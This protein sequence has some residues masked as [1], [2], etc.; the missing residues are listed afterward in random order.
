MKLYNSKFYHRD[1]SWLRF[2]HRV[3][4]EA[5]DKLNPLYERIKFLAIFS[6]NLDE[7]FRVRVSDIRQIR[8]VEK[9]LRK[10]L[11]TKPNKVL[12]EIKKQVDIQQTAFGKV[13]KEEIIPDL[14]KENIFLI[15]YHEFSDSQKAIANDYFEKTLKDLLA[16]ETTYHKNPDTIF[17]ENEASYLCTMSGETL[18]LV[19]IP[20]S[21]PRF[22]SFPSEGGKHYISFID[23][24]LKYNLAKIHPDDA[25][26]Y[27]ALKIS[28]DAELYIEDE[29]SGD[30]MKKIKASLPKRDK[31]QPTR[32]L[33][34]ERMPKSFQ[35]ILMKAL[36]VYNADLILGGRHHN[37]K[38]FFSFPNPTENEKLHFEPLPPL[39]HPVLSKSKN[40]FD[41]I[42]EKDQLLNYPY[43]A[44]D[45]VI[46]LLE[47]AASDPTVTAI[48]MTL[49]RLAN[50]SR[51][52]TAIAKAAKNGKEVI[53]FIEVKARF[54]EQN[55]IKWGA[56]FKENGA[57]VIYSYA[58]I[59]VHSKILYIERLVNE[60]IKRYAYISTGNF[61]SKT[62]ELYADY[63]LMTAHK[64]I[65]KDLNKVFMVLQGITLIPKTKC[66][67]VSPFS[68]RHTL[69]Q[70][71]DQ[72]ME[73]ARDGKEAYI[74]LKMNSFQDHALIKKLYDANN[75]G[76]KIKLI[77]RGM[78]S[79]VAGIEN[80]SEHI[81][82]ISILDR[83]L[84]HGR[85]Y[86]FGNDGDEI[87]YIGSADWMTR[88]LKHRIEVLTPI[89]DADIHKM[90]R[91]L[92]D[93][94][95]KDNV[96]ARIIDAEQTNTYVKNSKPKVRAQYATYAY[97]EGL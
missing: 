17:V 74:I 20:D 16:L 97:F 73:N 39:P 63:G 72:E 11:I 87:M 68:T 15:D 37:F 56:I 84:E 59:K 41:T 7:F 79:L 91:E 64:K 78:C 2:N 1:L 93:I 30:L 95:L 57:K 27:Y 45:P 82:V 38:D 5:S 50:E 88:N 3:L 18:H 44:F 32:V 85:V 28:R 83:F 29:F 92:V 49:Y 53:L 13:F 66:L 4:Q 10:K 22:F 54:D 6:S 77:V 43:E 19:K 40:I 52:N 12:Q 58:D 26:R 25:V 36:D 69:E 75:V 71:V 24:I 34:D 47:T 9:P 21:E 51:L 76:V 89:L 81:E 94:Q 61:N 80:Q 60:E 46:T 90:L 23:D 55:N 67:L 42:E 65:T 62:A 8:Q 86:I 48:K 96:K 33:I 31:G 70:L 35:D 14:E